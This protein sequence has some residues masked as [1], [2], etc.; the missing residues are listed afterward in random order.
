M[1]QDTLGKLKKTYTHLA[2]INQKF[3]STQFYLEEMV[4]ADAA[5]KFVT[6]FGNSVIAQI[7]ALEVKEEVVPTSGEES[8]V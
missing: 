6:E 4:A 3:L 8:N 1:P 5:M 7:E 2:F